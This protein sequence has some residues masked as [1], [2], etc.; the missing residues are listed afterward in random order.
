MEIAL[1][2]E[3]LVVFLPL[4]RVS[5]CVWQK[6]S[7][8]YQQKTHQWCTAGGPSTAIATF[9]SFVCI[10]MKPKL[11]HHTIKKN[12]NK[13]LQV[14]IEKLFS[15]KLDY[16]LYR[17]SNNLFLAMF[18]ICETIC[19]TIF[20]SPPSTFRVLFHHHHQNGPLPTSFTLLYHKRNWDKF[21][22]SLSINK[23]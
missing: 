15:Y 3:K 13:M 12:G 18:R 7:R 1:A 23:A 17:S 16:N 11:N 8:K 9:P 21:H 22:V 10:T 4:T 20:I 5:M 14:Q 19:C 2:L 6:Q